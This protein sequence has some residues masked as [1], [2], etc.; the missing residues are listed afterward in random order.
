MFY[1]QMLQNILPGHKVYVGV[2]NINNFDNNI[3]NNLTV[4]CINNTSRVAPV[5]MQHVSDYNV[6][7]NSKL[8]DH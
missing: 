4:S 6:P 1:G 7:N 3:F 8:H 5:R 2:K